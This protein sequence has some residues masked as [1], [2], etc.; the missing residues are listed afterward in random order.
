MTEPR[1]L[2]SD[3]CAKA[4]HLLAEVV[5][6]GDKL[7]VRIPHMPVEALRAGKNFTDHRVTAMH[8]QDVTTLDS[9][10]TTFASC[11]CKTDHQVEF[12]DLRRRAKS[13]DATPKIVHALQR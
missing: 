2:A 4:G 7:I 9:I 6:D 12:D 1:R 3:R 10:E 5:A 11:G 13:G 8:S